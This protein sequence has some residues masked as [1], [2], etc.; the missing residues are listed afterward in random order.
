[1]M[2]ISWIITN[3]SRVL[4]C[5][6]L[7]HSSASFVWKDPRERFDKI[8]ASQICHLHKEIASSVQG[9]APVSVYFSRL[10]DR[11]KYDSTPPPFCKCEKSNKYS[12]HLPKQTLLEFLTGPND[13][14]GNACVKF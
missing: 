12:E 13:G 9:I 3:V 10:K 7:F 14:Y 6:I 5:R 11:D 1:M 8:N 2:M 4:L